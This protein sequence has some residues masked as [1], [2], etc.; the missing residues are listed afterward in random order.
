MESI[1]GVGP[2]GSLEALAETEAQLVQEGEVG[3]QA[4]EDDALVDRLKTPAVCTD[5]G[6]P[7]G[8]LLGDGGAE[9]GDRVGVPVVDGGLDCEPRAPRAGICSAAPAP[10]P[11]P[12]AAVRLPA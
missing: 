8:T 5:E 6:R 11:E 1:S 10:E 7:V 4:G 2:T 12:M 3:A 9:A